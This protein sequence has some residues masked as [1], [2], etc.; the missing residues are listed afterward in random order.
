M[1]QSSAQTVQSKGCTPLRWAKSAH[2]S[3]LEIVH[4]TI[5]HGGLHRCKACPMPV[6]AVAQPGNIV[7]RVCD[8]FLAPRVL[9]LRC[10]GE[11][12]NE[13]LC[14]GSRFRPGLSRCGQEKFLKLFLATSQSRLI[15]LEFMQ[16][17]AANFSGFHGSGIVALIK[18]DRVVGHGLVRQSFRAQIRNRASTVS[19][20]ALHPAL[21][22]R[23]GPPL[24]PIHQAVICR[25][26]G[27]DPKHRVASLLCWRDVR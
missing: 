14:L 9:G 27:L 24:R 12:L 16:P 5:S 3:A 18:V 23:S 2:R 8:E 21:P 17:L 25:T 13:I 10:V 15:T 4:R 1:V 26:F 6:S 19:P 11:E 7:E 20:V 22:V